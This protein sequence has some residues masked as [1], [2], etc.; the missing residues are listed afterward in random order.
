VNAGITYSRTPGMINGQINYANSASPSMGIV[1]S[2]NISE[3]LDFTL[4]SNTAYTTVNNSLQTSLNS[5]FTNQNSRFRIQAQPW[6]GLVLQTELNHQLFKGL[7]GG[8]N[9][10]FLLWNAGIG[11]KFLKKRAAELRLT[12][13]DML[14]QNNSL[15]RNITETY[16]E[17]VQTNVLQRYYMLTFT[18]NLRA[19]KMPEGKEPQRMWN[20]PH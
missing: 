12:A 15:N 13:F 7:S 3:K 20:H 14:K 2:S 19:F 1:V 10:N 5:V 17:D 4:S 6:K 8:L 18:Y 16:Y 11:Y 9:N